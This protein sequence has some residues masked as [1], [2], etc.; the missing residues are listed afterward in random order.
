MVLK[1]KTKILVAM[2]GGVDSSVA[3][4]IL[5]NQG[6]DVTGA[7]MVNYDGEKK[8]GESCWHGDY[9]DALRVAAH[10][11][12]PLIRLDFVQEYK[13]FVLDYLYKEY[14]LGRTPNPDVMCN[15]F[16]KFGFWLK[17]A[18]KLGFGYLSTGHYANLGNGKN[19]KMKLI[20]AKDNNKDQTYFL[21][22]LNQKQLQKILFPI[23]KY[24]KPEVRQLAVKFKLPTALKEES[25]GI[26]FVGE[27]SMRDF[28]KDKIKYKAGD[29]ITTSGEKIGK[30]T[31]LPFYTIGERGLNLSNSDGQS[32]FVVDKDVK[33]NILIVGR[34]DDPKL[35]NREAAIKNVNWIS[36]QMP[37]FPLKCQVRMRH[38]QPLVGCILKANGRL[39]EA[40]FIK[41]ERAITPGQFAVFYKNNICLGGGE[42]K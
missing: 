36:G 18:E 1:K 34:A 25:M 15:K 14:S 28:L 40:Q 42:V 13:K 6:Y 26:C 2:S 30:H 39:V 12:I 37:K 31:G 33:K 32:Y 16:V 3:A 21:H 41:P 29:I 38:R 5:V 27:V 24:T 19:G 22:Q 4:A 35:F 17:A 9:Q 7:F 20:C 10:I 8:P 11:G 23:G